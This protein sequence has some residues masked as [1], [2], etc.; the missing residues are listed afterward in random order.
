MEEEAPEN[1]IEGEWGPP[2]LELSIIAE[3]L[4]VYLPSHLEAL[5]SYLEDPELKSEVEGLKKKSREIAGK[6]E[7]IGAAFSFFAEPFV[8]EYDR[9]SVYRVEGKEI[10]EEAENLLDVNAPLYEAL[11]DLEY[12]AQKFVST[13][14]DGYRKVIEPP[15]TALGQ[16]EKIKENV[17]AIASMLNETEAAVGFLSTLVRSFLESRGNE[18]RQFTAKAAEYDSP[19]GYKGI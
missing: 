15:Y 12:V 4:R 17:E 3:K 2:S 14:Y 18:L 8:M 11:S 13:F 9:L 16:P 5:K 6:L 19:R 7:E 1:Y 10:S